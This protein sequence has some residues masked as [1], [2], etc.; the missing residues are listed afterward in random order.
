MP[1]ACFDAKVNPLKTHQKNRPFGMIIL[2]NHIVYQEV[3]L[4]DYLAKI[5]HTYKMS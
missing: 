3:N 1:L 2:A 5:T 4:L